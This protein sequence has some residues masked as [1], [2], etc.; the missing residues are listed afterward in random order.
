MPCASGGDVALQRQ[1]YVAAADGAQRHLQ[2]LVRRDAGA[3]GG[4]EG[5]ALAVERGGE[6]RAE[7]EQS[8]VLRCQQVRCAAE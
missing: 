3:E 6:V 4:N 8:A 2:P 1:F 5:H 7:P